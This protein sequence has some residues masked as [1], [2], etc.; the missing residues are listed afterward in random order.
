MS[1][2]AFIKHQAE[3]VAREASPRK[4]SV[5]YLRVS[6]SSQVNTDYN[7]EGISL[8]AQR[9]RCL[10][11]CEEKNADVVREFVEPGRTATS[12]DKRPVFQEMIAWVKEQGDIDY[13]VVYH[14]NRIFR[15][16]V[17]AGLIKRD[18]KRVGTRVVSATIDV[19]DGPEGAM[20]ETILSAVDQYQSQASGADISY[21]MGTKAKNG[22]TIS[23]T[24]LGYL[25]QRDTSEGRN[26]GI[27]VPDPQRAQYIPIAFELYATRAWSLEALQDELTQRG[28]RTKPGR[29]SARP[30]SVSKLATMLRDPYYA[31]YVV[32]R[33]EMIEGRHQPL[34]SKGLY[35]RV[36]AIMDER[37][38]LGTRQRRHHHY[39]K[40]ILFCGR[41]H[42]Q[43]V[44]SRMLMQWSKGNGGTYRYFFCRRRQQHRC[45]ARYLEGDGVEAAV[46]RVYND[47]RFDSGLADRLR[48]AMREALA[49][50]HLSA[51]LL[52]R[53]LKAELA[54][55]D[56]QEENLIDLAAEGE[57]ATVKV[58]KRLSEIQR[59]RDLVA[60]RVD[61]Q[62]DELEVAVRWI[63]AALS[64]LGDPGDMYLRM[65]DHGR[66]KMNQAIFEKLYVLD[67]EVTDVVFNQP[68]GDLLGA[69]E[70]LR[71]KA[72]YKRRASL[73][74]FDWKFS[75]VGSEDLSDPLAEVLLVDG[76]SKGLVVE[77]KGLEPSASTLR[78]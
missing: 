75:Q 78:T 30:V 14:F 71:E 51:K 43:G 26:I 6:T 17:D 21:K 7:P 55:L 39:L 69:Q 49:E 37:C 63:E 42:E 58:R 40:G 60:E 59:K 12:I 13:I 2:A 11:K 28:L 76:L 53:Q 8:P 62:V 16:S 22:G 41:C 45:D 5:L 57:S 36:Q 15:D 31:G 3:A 35:D 70:I 66:Q 68:F 9:E 20:I 4:K 34:V 50:R 10:P 23:G 24:K 25:N 52:T 56:K 67:G 38:E 46:V 48:G 64:L 44:E 18:L 72:T 54:K 32:Y 73:P 29:Y 27:V 1:D 65:P 74:A 47:L 19:G 77:V 61:N 33:G